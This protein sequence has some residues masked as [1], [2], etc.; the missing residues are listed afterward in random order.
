MCVCPFKKNSRVYNKFML[1]CL[2][3]FEYIQTIFIGTLS[4]S[5]LRD[6]QTLE[7]EPIDTVKETPLK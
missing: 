5:I 3:T 2:L 6:P 4:R 1:K 7:H